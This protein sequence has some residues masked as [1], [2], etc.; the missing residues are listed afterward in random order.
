MSYEDNVLLKLRRD[1]S[2]V[3]A[4]AALSK[5]LTQVETENGQ[6]KSELEHLEHQLKTQIDEKEIVK[7]AKIEARKEKLYQLKLNENA[8]L[9][10]E[11]QRLQK[12]KSE[13]I[14]EVL[15]LKEKLK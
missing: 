8:R 1:Y 9:R 11:N 15:L 4:V 5:K 13:L 10:K 3:E 6:L 12:Y 14:N 7:I 2:E